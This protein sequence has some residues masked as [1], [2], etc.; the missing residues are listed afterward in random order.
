MLIADAVASGMGVL[1]WSRLKFSLIQACATKGL[2]GFLDTNL[3]YD[4][5]RERSVQDLTEI[6]QDNL[7]KE[8]VR[9]PEVSP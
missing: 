8:R 6:L 9:R 7:P 2:K 5:D 4:L 1:R 3:N